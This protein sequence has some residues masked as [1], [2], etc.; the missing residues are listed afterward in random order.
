MELDGTDQRLL[1][2]A[3]RRDLLYFLSLPL[4]EKYLAGGQPFCC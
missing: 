1:A 4:K 2:A 3:D